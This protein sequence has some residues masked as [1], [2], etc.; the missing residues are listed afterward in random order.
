MPLRIG[1]LAPELHYT[2]KDGTARSLRDL[3]GEKNAIVYFYPADFT[4]VCT[5]E[6]CA[7]RDASSELAAADTEIIG[8][9]SDSDAR[10]AEF[11]TAY[12]VPF[13]LVADPELT[14]AKA[15]G[16]A[17]LLMRALGKTTRVTYVI[18]K[19]GLIR[20]VFEGMLSAAHHVDGA[21]A[22]IRQ[23]L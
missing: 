15:W 8:V 7:F 14:V 21:R 23:G 20:G 2:T 17:P 22:L 9:S 6:T 5:R 11:A 3:R 19:Q 13:A 1:T 18:D 10:H 12:E 4:K 16:A